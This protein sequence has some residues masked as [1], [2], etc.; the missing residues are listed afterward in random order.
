V[1]SV[2]GG[3]FVV[4]AAELVDRPVQVPPPAGDLDLD[5]ALGQQLRDI[6]VGQPSNADTSGP[7]W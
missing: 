4:S 5:P 3:E 1:R 6:S 7:R 2:I